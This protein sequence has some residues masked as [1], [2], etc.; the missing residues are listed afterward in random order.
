MP[1]A[2]LLLLLST[3]AAT[4]ANRTYTNPVIVGDWPDPGAIHANGTWFVATTGGGFAI[5][6]SVTLGEWALAGSVFDGEGDRPAWASGDF[7]APEIHQVDIHGRCRL[8]VYPACVLH[9]VI[10]HIKQTRAARVV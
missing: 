8:F 6:R 5:H 1:F 9:N 2:L 10:L 3:T 7:W 4:D